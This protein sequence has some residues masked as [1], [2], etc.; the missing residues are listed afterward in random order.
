MAGVRETLAK[1]E[2]LEL[3]FEKNY[4]V[5]QCQACGESFIKHTVDGGIHAG[6]PGL[7]AVRL[8]LHETKTQ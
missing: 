4:I 5:S 3:D 2:Q 6:C 1:H 8:E 7:N